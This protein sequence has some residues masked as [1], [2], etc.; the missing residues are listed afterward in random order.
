MDITTLNKGVFLSKKLETLRAD[1][2]SIKDL[3]ANPESDR[4]EMKINDLRNKKLID[5]PSLKMPQILAMA[6]LSKEEELAAAEK[7]FEEL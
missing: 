7:E 2:Q 5:F 4:F 6:L 1:V 3:Q